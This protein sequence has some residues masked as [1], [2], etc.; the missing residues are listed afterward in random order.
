M[1]NFKTFNNSN[2]VLS[3]N[4]QDVFYHASHSKRVNGLRKGSADGFG[5]G[6]YFGSNKQYLIDDYGDYVT[7]VKLSPSNPVYTGSDEWYELEKTAIQINNEVEGSDIDED[8]NTFDL[9][10]S[11]YVS[12]AANKLGYDIIIDENV[13]GVE[14]VVLNSSIIEYLD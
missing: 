14:L 1:K 12:D 6:I 9:D 2:K 10:K 5:I 3:I 7:S 8:G 4:G 11:R 13:N